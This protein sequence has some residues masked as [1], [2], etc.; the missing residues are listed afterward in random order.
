MNR[1]II[2]QLKISVSRCFALLTI[3]FCLLAY[4]AQA[5]QVTATA[6]IDSVQIAIGGQT[7]LI[8]EVQHP[9][10]LTIKFPVLSDTIT[11]SV[12]IVNS[13]KE[14]TVSKTATDMIVRKIY[15][16]TSFDSGVHLIPAIKLEIANS[17]QFAQTQ[18][19]SLTVVNPFQNVD[20][21]KGL[22]DI[23]EPVN[24]PFILSELLPYL[25]WAIGFLVVVAA[26]V[27]FLIWRFNRKLVIPFINKEKP[28]DPC[29]VIALRE[30]ERIKEEKLWQKQQTKRYY[31][32]ITNVLRQYIE[33]RFELPALEQTSVEILTSLKNID[34]VS[35]ENHSNLARLLST[36]DLVKFAKMEPMADEN[37]VSMI[38]AI[39]FVN[40]TKY[41]EPKSLEEEKKVQ[42]EK[43]K[44]E[45]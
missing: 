3:A 19:L 44:T 8:I 1:F 34:V 5:Q 17:Q 23:K 12:E 26:I 32:E 35:G 37:E 27:V 15:R 10:G 39:F 36:A 2:N 18:P 43:Q 41:E 20:P 9:Q 38:N 31:S 24:T 11:K 28:K 40:Q 4:N 42:L 13:G 30:L 14:E 16:I 33:E 25:P 7:N 21:K 29:H 22:Y 6:K 45:A